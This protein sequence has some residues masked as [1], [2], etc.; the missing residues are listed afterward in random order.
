MNHD[1]LKLLLYGLLST[2]Q[3]SSIIPRVVSVVGLVFNCF[4]TLA[5]LRAKPETAVLPQ[6]YPDSTRQFAGF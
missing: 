5:L 2:V 6:A 1:Q 3:L 4:L